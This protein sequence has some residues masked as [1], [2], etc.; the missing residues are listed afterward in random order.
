MYRANA[1]FLAGTRHATVR[2]P[3]SRGASRGIPLRDLPNPM[4]NLIESRQ[5]RAFVAVARRGSF[6]HGAKDVFL[7]QSAVSHAIKSMETDLGCHLFRRVGK[8]AVLT[9]AGERMLQ[10]CE[11][12]LCKMQ[13]ARDDLSQ[14]PGAGQ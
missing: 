7:T 10:H 3:H 5:I 9:E 2:M 4:K 14:L 12:I 1:R 6:T 13:D 8:H 11:E